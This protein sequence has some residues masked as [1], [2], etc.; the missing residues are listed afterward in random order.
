[1]SWVSNCKRWS[2][3]EPTWLPSPSGKS[4]AVQKWEPRKIWQGKAGRREM[5]KKKYQGRYR[6]I[7]NVLRSQAGN[8]GP[9][10]RHLL[11]EVSALRQHVRPHLLERL[12]ESQKYRIIQMPCFGFYATIWSNKVGSSETEIKSMPKLESRVF[13]FVF[14]IRSQMRPLNYF[15][16]LATERS[17]TDN[18][19]G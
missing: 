3:V 8:F 16:G 7:W 1:M 12:K 19:S 5:E 13:Q 4:Q 10:Q 18:P 15:S 2:L 9:G 11:Q 14:F 17:K 6:W